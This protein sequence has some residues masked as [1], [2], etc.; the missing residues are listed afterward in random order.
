MLKPDSSSTIARAGIGIALLVLSTSLYASGAVNALL[1]LT[2]WIAV[3]AL[4]TCLA[5]VAQRRKE[6]VDLPA[7]IARWLR[8]SRDEPAAE[9]HE[10]MLGSI[11]AVV[12]NQDPIFR[13]LADSRLQTIA[14]RVETLASGIIEYSSTESW[15]V[16][17]EQLLRSPGLHL[18]RSVS[19]VESA[20]YWQDGP[21]QQSTRLNLELHD[22]RII[23]VERTAIIADH[24]W[25]DDETFPVEPIRTWL[26]EQHQ[27]GIWLRLVRESVIANE[28]DLLADFGIYGSRAVGVQ[29][30]DAA[31]RTLR[32]QLSFDFDRVEQAE[33]IWE[34]LSVYATPYREL[35]ERR[36]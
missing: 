35:L 27:H 8:I 7:S 32:F 34:R 2:C 24:L 16:A 13:E 1:L 15:R 14:S 21:G 22:A 19:H 12:D 20:H 23:S 26:D 6:P 30:A 17:Y 10:R 4:V 18:Y 25:P 3:L 36:L 9:V 28:P 29:L 31:G 5:L 33:S 11:E